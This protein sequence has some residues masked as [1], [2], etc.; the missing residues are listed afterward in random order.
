MNKL[1]TVQNAAL[2]IATGCTKD[3]NTQHLHEETST[4]PI[5]KH[6]QLHSSLY[7]QKAQLP[8]HPLFTLTKRALKS[9]H[10]KKQ[11]LTTTTNSQLKLQQTLH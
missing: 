11:S 9:R 6:I 8:Q 5:A 7:E 2:R 1:Q 10:L 4:L 3:T